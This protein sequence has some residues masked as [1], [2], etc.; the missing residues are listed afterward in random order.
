MIKPRHFILLASTLAAAFVIGLGLGGVTP[1]AAQRPTPPSQAE[2][3]AILRRYGSRHGLAAVDAPGGVAG[4]TTLRIASSGWKPTEVLVVE[5]AASGGA[6]CAAPF[7]T[8]RIKQ[9]TCRTGL[10]RFGSIEVPLSGGG[11]SV[12]VY[13]LDPTKVADACASFQAV[14]D[15][16]KT[17][18]QWEQEVWNTSYGE[19]LAV[20]AVAAAG[21]GTT[22]FDGRPALGAGRTVGNQRVAQNLP[23][24]WTDLKGARLRLFNTLP[25]CLQG[26]ATAGGTVEG[27]DCPTPLQSRWNVPA[28]DATD[29]KLDFGSAEVGSLTMVG[30]APQQ[31]QPPAVLTDLLATADRLDASG[32]LSY[33]RTPLLTANAGSIAFP[34]AVAPL[35]N[36]KSELW[37]SNH[38]VT[39]TV[40]VN[41]L[42][43]D[44]NQAIHQ[45]YTD[46]VGLCPGATRRYNI[47]EI[48]GEIPPSNPPRGGGQAGPPVLS[49]RV[50]A[51]SP[52]LQNF[53]PISGVMVFSSATGVTAYRGLNVPAELQALRGRAESDR[54]G[55]TSAVVLPGVKKAYGADRMT[56]FVMAMMLVGAQAENAI[57][58]DFYDSAGKPVVVGFTRAMGQGPAAYFDLRDVV[59]PARGDAQA[60]RLPDGF[61]GTAVIRGQQNRGQMGAMAVERPL[62][63]GAT[64]PLAADGPNSDSPSQNTPRD[65]LISY[66]GALLLQWPDPDAP[67]TPTNVPVPTVGRMTPTPGVT[68]SPG[69]PSPE[70]TPTANVVRFRVWLPAL[71]SSYDLFN[72][73]SASQGLP[74]VR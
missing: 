24:V 26:A 4:R 19:P 64:R 37:V 71:L 10:G 8:G 41:L 30:T 59:V 6:D 63:G 36:L 22:A 23:V 55:P 44:G 70:A 25:Q 49:L 33:D 29:L 66:G 58:V 65:T 50:E 15:G 11:G 47:Q 48:A 42:M 31:G 57:T 28:Y 61:I 46:P 51:T 14:R 73:P 9:A 74:A 2:I 38:N 27:S 16:Q 45:S 20:Q 72:P 1:A 56:S 52:V 43:F 17:L 39:A 21:D 68:V 40:T 3:E 12:M 60:Q 13:S 18:M 35:D 69:V 7:Q 67:A 53:A 54:T 62:P 32:W 34:M 5:L